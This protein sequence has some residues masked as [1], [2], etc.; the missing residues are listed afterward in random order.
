MATVFAA[1]MSH[2]PLIVPE[3]GGSDS[4]PCAGTTKAMREIAQRTVRARPDRVVVISPHSPRLEH[5][6]GAWRGEHRGHLGAFGAPGIRVHL[7]DA[8]VVSDCLPEI[9]G[10]ALDHGAVVPLWF[11]WEA[12]W[13]GPT[14]IIALPEDGDGGTAFG[15]YLATLPGRTAVIASGDMSHHLDPLGAAVGYHPR[16]HEFD[17]S[18]VAALAADDWAAA[19]AA[20]P[21]EFTDE[22]V[23]DATVLTMAAAGKPLHAEV[24]RYEAPQGVGHAGV[25][26]FDPDPPLYAMARLSIRNALMG[27][28]CPR[29]ADGP[30]ACGVYVSMHLGQEARGCGSTISVSHDRLHNE[31]DQVVAAALAALKDGRATRTTLGEL[32]DIRFEVS[33]LGPLETATGAEDLEPGRFGLFVTCGERQALLPPGA[34]GIQTPE[35][36]IQACRQRA[37]VGPDEPVTLQ[38][39]EVLREA[40]R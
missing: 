22:D 33:L 25:V 28:P 24:L 30:K 19:A 40:N 15:E 32:P 35:E 29:F 10:A 11:L 1:L 26:L 17:E 18:F 12:G 14:S 37:G 36:Q 5:G 7:P 27:R 13:R 34:E 2:A 6:L 23:L 4:A 20:G 3:V 31:A 38:R 16:A 9:G 21:R 39:F 8:P